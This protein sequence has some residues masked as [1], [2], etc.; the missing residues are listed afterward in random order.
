MT[1]YWIHVKFTRFHNFSLK[2]CQIHQISVLY[3]E[4]MSNSLDFNTFHWNHVKFIRFQY[5]SL[6][7]CQIH[8]ISVLFIEIH[9]NSMDFI[10]FHWNHIKFMDFYWFLGKSL[11]LPP[12]WCPDQAQTSHLKKV[13]FWG[14]FR[15][16]TGVKA[17]D[18]GKINVI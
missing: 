8:Q 16:V 17:R 18:F 4:I 2:S 14:R 10:D 7:S 15:C 6:K 1:F 11:I 3:I 13:W 9:S 5:F 12:N